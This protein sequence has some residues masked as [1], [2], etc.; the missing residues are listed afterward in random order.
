[1]CAALSPYRDT[2]YSA[3][4]LKDLRWR[5]ALSRVFLNSE[6]C[7]LML[8]CQGDGSVPVSEWQYCCPKCSDPPGELAQ[9]LVRVQLSRAVIP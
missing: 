6:H 4:P 2:V 3:G 9:L 7:C 5:M 1:M 8:T